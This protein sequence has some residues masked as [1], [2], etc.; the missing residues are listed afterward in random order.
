MSS[1]PAPSLHLNRNSQ[2]ETLRRGTWRS[3]AKSA[4]ISHARSSL[5]RVQ[6]LGYTRKRDNAKNDEEQVFL[7]ATSKVRESGLRTKDPGS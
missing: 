2:P 1:K 7:C 6:C 4:S 5:L 3:S